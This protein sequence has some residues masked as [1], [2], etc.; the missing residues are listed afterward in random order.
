MYKRILSFV[1]EE[2]IPKICQ[3]STIVP[4]LYYGVKTD[5]MADTFTGLVFLNDRTNS[6]NSII[7]NYEKD[8]YEINSL[9]PQNGTPK[10]MPESTLKGFYSLKYTN[11]PTPDSGC[12]MDGQRTTYK[13]IIKDGYIYNIVVIVNVT[14]YCDKQITSSTTIEDINGHITGVKVINKMSQ[15]I[16]VYTPPT[17]CA[18]SKYN[19]YSNVHMVETYDASG[20]WNFILTDFSKATTTGSS[21]N[22]YPVNL[23]KA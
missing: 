19:K 20:E 3:E 7:I 11:G 2:K 16:G 5:V 23:G 17:N 8:I 4:N 18:S 15:G 6:S 10:K 13:Y 21:N 14:L 12:T 9:T 1:K 22:I